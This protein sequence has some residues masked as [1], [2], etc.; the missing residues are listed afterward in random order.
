MS[1]D[2]LILNHWNKKFPLVLRK[3]FLVARGIRSQSMNVVTVVGQ[4]FK[5]KL[6]FYYIETTKQKMITFW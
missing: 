5:L 3:E 2:N 1:K 4:T 6:F